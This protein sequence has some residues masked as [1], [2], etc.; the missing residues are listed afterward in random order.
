MQAK[1]ISKPIIPHN[2]ASAIPQKLTIDET[3]TRKCHNLEVGQPFF[4]DFSFAVVRTYA[5]G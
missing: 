3:H 2:L 1:F 5:K 4:Q